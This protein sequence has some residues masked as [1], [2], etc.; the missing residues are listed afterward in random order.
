MDVSIDE[1][2]IVGTGLHHKMLVVN[3][4]YLMVCAK[5]CDA[6]CSKQGW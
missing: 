3:S 2:G 4:I 6:Q 1:H 5:A